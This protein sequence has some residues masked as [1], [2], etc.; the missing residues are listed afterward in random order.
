MLKYLLILLFVPATIP[1]GDHLLHWQADQKLTWDD[2]QGPADYSTDMSAHTTSRINYKWKCAGGVFEASVESTFD[3]EKS[4]KKDL[5][6]D[7]LLA[8]EQLHFDITEWHAR[9]LRKTFADLDD[10]C[11]MPAEDIKAIANEIREQWKATQDQYDAEADHGRNY[12]AQDMWEQSVATRL[13][14]LAEFASAPQ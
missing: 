6:T 13:E 5:Q 7:R 12:E 2:F 11:Q 9:K 10:P 3:R 4:W 14:M 8:H 1:G